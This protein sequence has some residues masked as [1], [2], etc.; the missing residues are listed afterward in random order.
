MKTNIFLVG[1]ILIIAIAFAGCVANEE[2]SEGTGEET[3]VP[4]GAENK[5]NGFVTFES[6]ESPFENASIRITLEDVSLA[7]VSSVLIAETTLED[8]SLDGTSDL[9]IPFELNYGDL[10]EGQTYSLSAHVDVDGDGVFSSGDYLTTEHVDVSPSGVEGTIEVPVEL[11][12]GDADGGEA[13]EL[14]SLTG[15]ITSIDFTDSSTMILVESQGETE[16]VYSEG[17]RFVISEDTN[18]VGLDGGIYYVEDLQEGFEVRV[19]FEPV[20]TSSL[21]PIAEATLIQLV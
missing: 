17:V 8:I 1:I 6:I 12:G 5:L 14:L 11:I 2:P 21:P 4:E 13:E 18:I 3:V 19:F 16:P 15:T 7:D 9:S 20:M 10:Q